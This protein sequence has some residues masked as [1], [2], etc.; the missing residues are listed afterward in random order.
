MKILSA[1]YSNY[2]GAGGHKF[3]IINHYEEY[4][5]KSKSIKGACKL[6]ATHLNWDCEK[7]CCP[8]DGFTLNYIILNYIIVDDDR[9]LFTIEFRRK[10]EEVA[11]Y[12]VNAAREKVVAFEMSEF[13]DADERHY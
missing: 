11:I 4:F 13:I 1:L 9:E 10:G 7:C 8:V 6:L 5:S 12:L 2:W 3:K